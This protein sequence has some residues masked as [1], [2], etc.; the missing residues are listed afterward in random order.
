VSDSDSPKNEP[1]KK[2]PIE[3]TRKRLTARERWE[4]LWKALAEEEVTDPTTPLKEEEA[5]R[6]KKKLL[7]RVNSWEQKEAE[8][9][10]EARPKSIN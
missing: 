3:K 4:N 6:T 7:E 1:P 8:R 2:R 10:A 5:E 9:K